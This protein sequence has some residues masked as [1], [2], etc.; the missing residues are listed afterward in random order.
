V[1]DAPAVAAADAAAVADVA[2]VDKEI[3]MTKTTMKPFRALGTLLRACVL[4]LLLSPLAAIAVD[5]STFATPEDAVAA[6]SD[7][8]KSPNDDA[9]LK[10]F[11]E[12]FRRLII[13]ADQSEKAVM[14]EKVLNAISTFHSFEESGKDRLTLVIG[15]HAWPLPIPLVREKGAWRFATEQGEDELINRRVGANER[16]AI[17]ALRGYV[18]AQR[19]Y[20]EVD[21][22]GDGVIE[23]AQRL[24]STPGKHDG[25]YWEAKEGEEMSPFGPLMAANE[26]YLK[27]SKEGAP[28]RGYFFR[29]LKRQGKSAPGG[30][31]SY[32]ING[33]MLAGFAMVAYPAEYGQSGVMTFVVGKNGV[34]YE[35]N[36]GPK[37]AAI[38]SYNPDASW[39]RVESPY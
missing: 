39:R 9:M 30:A 38:D 35:K 6:L 12:R 37:A 16:N 2:V 1:A 29:I 22:N 3:S 18:D 33:H 31:Y 36:L 19:Q 14:R 5:Q 26:A 27:G 25:L 13:P 15:D 20:A 11:G 32:V 28:F 8:L 4:A 10:V 23:Y 17:E 7:A 34:V 24:G 21:R